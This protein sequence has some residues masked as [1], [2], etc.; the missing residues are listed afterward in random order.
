FSKNPQSVI[1]NVKQPVTLECE[2]DSYPAAKITWYLG[3]NPVT[4][5]TVTMV[6]R[7]LSTVKIDSVS[8]SDEGSYSCL[9]T[10]TMLNQNVRSSAATLTVQGQPEILKS[11][12]SSSA[13]LGTPV[14]FDCEAAGRPSP[15]VTW[16]FTKTGSLPADRVSYPDANKMILSNV[17]GSDRGTYI[18]KAENT[19]GS[20][21]KSSKLTVQVRPSFTVT[22]T[23]VTVVEGEKATLACQAVGNPQPTL[24]WKTPVKGNFDL[25]LD[26]IFYCKQIN[27]RCIITADGTLTI[28][29]P[30]V[31]HHGLYVCTATNTVG[32]QSV[33]AQLNVQGPP[34]FVR[35]P[36]SQMAKAGDAS[37]TIPCRTIGY[38]KPTI[39]WYRFAVSNKLTTNSK[40]EITAEGDLVIKNIVVGDKA[41][42]V[43]Y[44]NNGYEK[45]RTASVNVVGRSSINYI[46][47]I[48]RISHQPGRPTA[49][50]IIKI[51][52]RE[53]TL[54]WTDGQV[55]D[56]PV[57]K[58]NLEKRVGKVV[59]WKP[60][61]MTTTD[62]Q[63]VYK[64]LDLLPYTSY[65]FRVSIT[66]VLTTGEI[67]EESVR[68]ESLA[69][70]KKEYIQR[71]NTTVTQSKLIIR[72]LGVWVV[73]SIG[74]SCIE[75]HST[76]VSDNNI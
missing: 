72:H 6:S 55:S 5:P 42:Y 61:N 58:Y 41:E 12:V 17:G 68:I 28:E 71:L 7:T 21:T 40:Y 23:T 65:I 43:C 14:L 56:L 11:P 34:V 62:Q 33:T 69:D 22:P 59:G 50:Q 2:I 49:P 4:K 44:A 18:C 10:N 46:A 26:P 53:V 1:G 9:A 25:T 45:I 54:T 57:L 27:K 13:P 48:N 76:R 19:Q 3:D 29:Q 70:G 67:S 52:A 31:K 64:A 66:N 38:P 47:K 75:C 8:Y 35:P 51:E 20:I 37:V 63:Y 74:L 32:S 39:S 24:S 60:S 30:E 36:V 73:L 15:T 16:Y